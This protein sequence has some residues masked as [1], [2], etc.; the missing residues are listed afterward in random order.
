MEKLQQEC[1]HIKYQL[2]YTYL[3]I[4]GTN[5][6]CLQLGISSAS[7]SVTC[8]SLGIMYL[9]PLSSPSNVTI[10]LTTPIIHHYYMPFLLS[11]STLSDTT[12]LGPAILRK[13]NLRRIL[14]NLFGVI[15]LRQ[16]EEGCLSPVSGESEDIWT[17]QA[18]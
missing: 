9:F 11:F 6:K 1:G 7:N 16:L 2:E 18:I 17:T 12:F 14:N 8:S 15:N 3:I 4:P 10:F 5:L 13:I